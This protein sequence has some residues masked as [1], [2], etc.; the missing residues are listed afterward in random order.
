MCEW[1]CM[2]CCRC[3]YNNSEKTLC[4]FFSHSLCVSF[5]S[6]STRKP[7]LGNTISIIL[8]SNYSDES[9]AI[10]ISVLRWK[11]GNLFAKHMRRIDQ[12]SN[13]HSI[14]RFRVVLIGVVVVGFRLE[15]YAH[16]LYILIQFNRILSAAFSFS[17]SYFALSFFLVVYVLFFTF[18]RNHI[19][20]FM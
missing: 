5:F 15:F 1:V 14:E 6:C 18:S 13:T 8:C 7:E 19:S 9:K 4:F 2:V 3:Y 16:I 10:R 20:T 17:F 12:Q 11:F